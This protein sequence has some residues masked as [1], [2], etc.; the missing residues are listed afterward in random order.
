[1]NRIP[2]LAA[3]ELLL[4][5]CALY[6]CGG[7]SIPEGVFIDNTS[8]DDSFQGQLPEAAGL[9]GKT[10]LV[11]GNSISVRGLVEKNY[12]QYVSEWLGCAVVNVAVGGTGYMQPTE[13]AKSW[14]D[15]IDS[16]PDPSEVDFIT[17]MGALND[18]YN[19]LGNPGDKGA[20]TFYGAIDAFY[21]KLKARYPGLPIGVITSTPR[22]Y[23]H[24]ESGD[25]VGFIDAVLGVSENY[26]LPSLDLY[27]LSELEP[28]TRAGNAEYF[29]A[30]S[31]YP[32]GDGIHPNTKGHFGMAKLIYPFI[33][34]MCKLR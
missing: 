3:A 31:S 25:Y 17:V 6:S 33:V 22:S 32:G 2:A 11:I 24:G 10:W 4:L 18:A 23:C 14:L 8:F 21:G 13:A 16:Y 1:M 7:G 12:E 26:E 15:S 28:W 27:R 34:E 20:S 19:P 29:I 9:Y 5:S 30:W